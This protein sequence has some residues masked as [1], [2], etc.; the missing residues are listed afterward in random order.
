MS[1]LYNVL[2]GVNPLAGTLLAMLHASSRTLPRFRDCFLSDQDTIVIYT[3]TGG[4]NRAEYA[5][6]NERLRRVPGFLHDDDDAFDSTYAKF[7]FAIP[8]E[9]KGYL[10]EMVRL[11]PSLIVNPERRW[12]E[13]IVAIGKD[14]PT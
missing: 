12:R 1:G 14:Q 13:T 11:E 5:R 3:R 8:E 2:F 7:H 10:E 9:H 4:G 6:E